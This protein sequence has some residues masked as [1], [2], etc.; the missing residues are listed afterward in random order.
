MAQCCSDLFTRAA[1]AKMLGMLIVRTGYTYR[2]FIPL[3]AEACGG[4]WG[5]EA[6]RTWRAL[7]ALVA[8]RTGEAPS[9]VVQHIY[10]AMSLTFQR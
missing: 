9:L 3:V 5:P 4:G 6:V 10:Q 1:A 2:L 7:G 8:A